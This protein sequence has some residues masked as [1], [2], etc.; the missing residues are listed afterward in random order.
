MNFWAP[1][2]APYMWIWSHSVQQTLNWTPPGLGME[3]IRIVQWRILIRIDLETVAH[4]RLSIL[5]AVFNHD[6]ESHITF[7]IPRIQFKTSWDLKK[8]ENFIHKE[9]EN[10]NTTVI[11]W[12][13]YWNYLTDFK[14]AITQSFRKQPKSY[15]KPIGNII[16]AEKY[17]MHLLKKIKIK[18]TTETN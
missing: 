16:L 18:P 12:H 7:K 6:P 5:S 11:R 2:Q 14:E 1:P 9:K 13:I 10:Q 15:L 17:M 3:Q 4:R 8:K